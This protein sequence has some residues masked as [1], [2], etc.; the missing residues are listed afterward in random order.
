MVELQLRHRSPVSG[1]DRRRL[2][3]LQVIA[4]SV[5]AVAPSAARWRPAR[6]WPR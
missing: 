6:R 5:S 4:Q 3:P 2:G 1:L